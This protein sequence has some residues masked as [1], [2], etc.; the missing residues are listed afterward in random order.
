MWITRERCGARDFSADFGTNGYGADQCFA[1][2]G[3]KGASMGEKGGYA[4]EI[5]LQFSEKDINATSMH[6]WVRKFRQ[7]MGTCLWG[8]VS[9]PEMFEPMHVKPKRGL[10]MIFEF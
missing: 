7:D 4:S 1:R 10:P 9:H 5:G 2:S 6:R 3:R 8:K